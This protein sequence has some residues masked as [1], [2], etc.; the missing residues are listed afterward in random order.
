MI[1]VWSMGHQSPLHFQHPA[2]HPKA[3][4]HAGN[5]C[6]IRRGHRSQ[7]GSEQYMENYIASESKIRASKQN[8]TNVL[9]NVL[10]CCNQG[11]WTGWTK[12]GSGRGSQ[13]QGSIWQLGDLCAE[14]QEFI[15]LL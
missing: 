11:A 4:E 9:S 10:M 1:Q 13:T 3:S 8:S 2:G 14:V 7:P 12:L 15:T 6:P 5:L